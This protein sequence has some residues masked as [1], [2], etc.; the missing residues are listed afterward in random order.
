MNDKTIIVL[1]SMGLVAFLESLA[2]YCGHDGVLL[3]TS[4]GIIGGLAGYGFKNVKD[5]E[6]K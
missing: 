6:K 4:I 2:L 1:A 3:T 5:Q